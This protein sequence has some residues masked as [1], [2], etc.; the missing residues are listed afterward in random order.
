MDALGGYDSGD[1][2]E[3]DQQGHGEGE[4]SAKVDFKPAWQMDDDGSDKSEDEDGEE[5][6]EGGTTSSNAPEQPEPP[7]KKKK[8]P[9]PLEALEVAAPTFLTSN[10]NEDEIVEIK[11]AEPEQARKEEAVK[12]EGP[13]RLD[14]V[15]LPPHPKSGGH[16][17]ISSKNQTSEDKKK[18]I[19]FNAREKRKRELGQASKDK[20]WVEEEKRILRQSGCD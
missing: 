10:D 16:G 2:D 12:P 5:G 1:S 17:P 20:N 7:V 9:N 3:Q 13:P 6:G 8:L 14:G 18:Q 4:G 11:Q 19:S 15:S